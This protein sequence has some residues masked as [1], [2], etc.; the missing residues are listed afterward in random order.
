VTIFHW[1]I[2][3]G[4]IAL[5]FMT[6]SP[7]MS[8]SEGTDR[9]R[10]GS[11]DKAYIQLIARNGSNKRFAYYNG[12]E[13]YR[14]N[15][16]ICQAG[17]TV[18][19]GF[20]QAE[21]TGS[22]PARPVN[23]GENISFRVKAPDGSIVFGPQLLQRTNVVAQGHITSYQQAV[24][25]PNTLDPV[26]GYIPFQFVAAQTGD[27]YIEFEALGGDPANLGFRLFDIT[28][29]DENLKRKDG[30]LWSKAWMLNTDNFDNPYNGSFYIL[31][32]DQIVTKM[33]LNGTRPYEFIFSANNTG[34]RN[35]GN[36]GLDRMSVFNGNQTYPLYK[37]FL[38]NP[39]TLCFKS[40]VLG[41]IVNTPILSGCA[42]N[43][44]INFTVTAA[45]EV[46]AFLNLNGIEGY[47][48]NTK[49]LILQAK[50]D[51]G[52][53]CIPWNGL[54]G[55]GKPVATGGTIP[56]NLLYMNG[57]THLPIFDVENNTKGYMV[58]YVR[59][60]PTV[61][62]PIKLYWD[63]SN[64]RPNS[65]PHG[66]IMSAGCTGACHTWV[67][68]SGDNNRP[69]YGNLNT[70]N[71]WWFINPSEKNIEPQLSS[72]QIDANRNTPG[73]GKEN[74]TAICASAKELGLFGG[75]V[76]NTQSLWTRL[77]GSGTIL[78][79]TSLTT[80]YILSSADSSRSVISL[81]IS[82][83]NGCGVVHDTISI[84]LN[85][86]PQLSLSAPP[87]PCNP[88]FV[89]ANAVV[90]YAKGV[91]WTGLSGKFSPNGPQSVRYE[92]TQEELK[93]KLIVLTATT[94]PDSTRLCNTKTRTL[95]IP[96]QNVT[97]FPDFEKDHKY[98]DESQPYVQLQS[99]AAAAYAWYSEAG[100]VISTERILRVSPNQ[101]TSYGLKITNERGC[102]DSVVLFVR[103]VCPPRLFVPNVITPSSEDVNSNL[104]IYGVHYTNFE[105]TIFSRWGEVIFNSKDPKHTWDGVYKNQNMPIGTYPWIVTYEGDSE[106][107]RGPYKKVGDVTVVR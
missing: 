82:A 34:T 33:N 16:H 57:L 91:T 37:V 104:S 73:K 60:L 77:S 42:P 99:T 1:V 93:T 62:N 40:G 55:L 3:G 11:N 45:G 81:M 72:Q 20:G 28:V 56:I 13:N 85:P 4:L 83:D 8:Y 80:K 70:I 89:V 2:D 97:D 18:N 86:N 14:L 49:D 100:N 88:S 5:L 102:S 12:E 10:T 47:Q 23:S 79:P 30:R 43:F 95:Q 7:L 15:I 38:N 101:N 6:V 24:A 58:D 61:M 107:Y 84:R 48:G 50:A 19:M 71:T 74:D 51:S 29:T 67:F 96:L 90:Q 36:S 105:I 64:I 63:D 76:G 26:N 44:C 41:A 68:T 17:E 103:V 21:S 9:V 78:N 75:L 39:D 52:D 98:C 92:P 25:G 54:D 65:G 31:S 69:D 53:N 27:Y 22:N 32:N 66:G 87:P 35:T 94:L 46:Q 106:E 59:P